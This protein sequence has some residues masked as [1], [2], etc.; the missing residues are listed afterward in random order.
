MKPMSKKKAKKKFGK[1]KFWERTNSVLCPSCG[2][3]NFFQGNDTPTEYDC[4]ACGKT[5]V[6]VKFKLDN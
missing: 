2:T 5:A 4:V 6:W 1:K 3:S